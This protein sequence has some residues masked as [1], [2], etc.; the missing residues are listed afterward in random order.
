MDVIL[1]A[2]ISHEQRLRLARAWVA[3]CAVPRFGERAVF[4]KAD[5]WHFRYVQFLQEAFSRGS[6]DLSFSRAD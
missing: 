4:I 6:L 1:R 3:A 5:C 2:P